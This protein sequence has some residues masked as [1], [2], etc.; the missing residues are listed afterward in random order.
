MEYKSIFKGLVNKL[1]EHK[2]IVVFSM[3]AFLCA[4]IGSSY[5]VF[6]IDTNSYVASEL[7]IT[8]LMFGI[9]IYDS[10][11]LLENGN[12]IVV[13]ADTTVSYDVEIINLNSIAAKYKL[14]YEVTGEN[15]KVYY[16]N[17]S[18]YSPVGY[19]DE[20]EGKSFKKTVRVTIVNNSS[21]ES[22]ISFMV[23]GGY[24]HNDFD[25]IPV[26]NEINE[27]YN[28][29]IYYFNSKS[30]VDIVNE[31]LKCE[32]Y[33]CIFKADNSVNNYVYYSNKLYR[34]VGLYEND[35]NLQVKLI[36]TESIKTTYLNYENVLNSYYTSLDKPNLYLKNGDFCASI[37]ECSNKN[38][39]ILSAWEYILENDYHSFLNTEDKSLTL[40]ANNEKVYAIMEN[41]ELDYID[42]DEE[43]SIHPVIYLNPNMR[44]VGTG[45]EQDP[46]KLYTDADF[47]ILNIY[48]NGK[49]VDEIPSDKEYSLDYSRSKCSNGET[50][51]WEK[52]ERKLSITPYTSE[53]N[54]K[55]Y[56]NETTTYTEELLL[57]ADPI[58]KDGL[59]PVVYTSNGSVKYANVEEK[60]YEYSN[61]N[62]ANAVILIDNPS[63]T[64]IVGDEI[65]ESDIKGYFVWI[66]KYSYTL[67]NT[68]NY[69]TVNENTDLSQS[70]NIVFG[71]NDTN[72]SDNSCQSN[73]SNCSN[74]KIMTHSAFNG[75][76]GFWISKFEIGN[77]NSTDEAS[78]LVNSVSPNDVVS[79][80]NTFSWKGI[81]H[82]NTFVN[83]YNFNRNMDS[84]MINNIEWG[85]VAYLTYSNYGK[86][87]DIN[88]DKSKVTSNLVNDAL[89]STTGNI[90]GVYDMA[91]KTPEFISAYVGDINL[92]GWDQNILAKYSLVFNSYDET[93]ESRILGDAT[94]EMGPFN[95][96]VS[97]W[98]DSKI[99]L[100][101][102]SSLLVRGTDGKMLSVVN[103]NGLADNDVTSRLV[104]ILQRD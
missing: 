38:I 44:V 77:R 19:I 73:S 12:T 98:Y 22:T 95:N 48:I 102:S 15:T 80:P 10:E 90:T 65:N 64:Y 75:N 5:S 82:F 99:E 54:C 16:S 52:S 25:A 51:L 43:A 13:P 101:K 93:R 85:A 55:I 31:R 56:L 59:I 104:L 11:E 9:N 36:D 61:K 45:I 57:G 3:V 71:V 100:F 33:P 69:G 53:A 74:G 34:I 92:G 2:N 58:L 83:L 79:K 42:L 21:S 49:E 50:I 78:S 7:Y 97:M 39:G 76:E 46:F 72:D 29:A 67:F 28:E 17:L 88:L 86:N 70:I 37:N 41:G 23:R 26:A 94:S 32:S 66:P 103:H 84:H 1:S 4:G 60:W 27:K 96:D 89:T 6:L 68:N 63:K 24:S 8:N 35:N 47:R 62:W 20:Y 18:N 87:T 14:G 91:N 40:T 30:L 81:S